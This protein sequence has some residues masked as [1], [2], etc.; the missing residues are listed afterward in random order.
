LKNE[1]ECFCEIC[2]TISLAPRL[3]GMALLLH[4][5]LA[6]EVHATAGAEPVVLQLKPVTKLLL[7]L[8]EVAKAASSMVG[9][10]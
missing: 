9:D 6:V 7:L 5:S 8:L 2:D 4:N 1:N 10:C 3:D